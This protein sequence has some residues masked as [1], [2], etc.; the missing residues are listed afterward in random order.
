MDEQ[1]SLFQRAKFFGQRHSLVL[2]CLTMIVAGHM[3]WRWIQQQP[4]IVKGKGRRY[5]WY[6]VSVSLLSVTYQKGPL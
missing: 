3:G 1:L 2:G 4:D 6:D 5:P